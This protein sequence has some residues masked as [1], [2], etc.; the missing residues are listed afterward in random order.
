MNPRNKHL[1]HIVEILVS[2]ALDLIFLE[3]RGANAIQDITPEFYAVRN[4]LSPT[5]TMPNEQLS[6]T[7]FAILRRF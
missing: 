1:R 6:L 2:S 5:K 3:A 4:N 7:E